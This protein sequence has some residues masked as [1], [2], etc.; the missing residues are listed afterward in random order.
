MTSTKRTEIDNVFSANGV[1]FDKWANIENINPEEKY[2]IEKYFDRDSQKSTVEAGTGGGRILLE[3]YEMGFRNLTGFDYVPEMIDVA[4]RRK[5]E[6]DIIFNVEDATNL[7]YPEASFDRAFYSQQILSLMPDTACR[8]SSF[9][10]ASRIVKPGGLVVFALLCFDARMQKSIYP[11]YLAYLNLFRK[12][13]GSSQES[14]YI[15][16]LIHHGKFNWPALADRGDRTYWYKIEEIYQICERIGL[17]VVSLGTRTQIQQGKMCESKAEILSEKMEGALY[18]VCR[19][20][21]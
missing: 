1:E 12:I 13:T 6:L 18:V 7:S 4:N 19:K 20:K 21:Y 9:Q 14:Q 10:E 5:G 2:I 11:P 15:P 3:M 8:L 17:E 16:W